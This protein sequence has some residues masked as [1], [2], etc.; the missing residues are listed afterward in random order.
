MQVQSVGDVLHRLFWAQHASRCAWASLTP[1]PALVTDGL[2]EQG[3]GRLSAPVRLR[4]T[5]V[6]PTL[7]QVVT[8]QQEGL[9][10]W[11][12]PKARALTLVP[13]DTALR[14]ALR[15]FDRVVRASYPAEASPEQA[16]AVIAHGVAVLAAAVSWYGATYPAAYPA[17]RCEDDQT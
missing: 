5:K 15:A 10:V 9:A 4:C 12:R 8:L 3:G 2:L 14:S 11:R 16:G 1:V 6:W 7:S 13:G 17:V